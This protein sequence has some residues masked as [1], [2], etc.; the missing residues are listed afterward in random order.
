MILLMTFIKGCCHLER[1]LCALISTDVCP[2]I[3]SPSTL[4]I[5]NYNR[6]LSKRKELLKS[7]L[8]RLQV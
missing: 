5:A 3:K 7:C 1:S 6:N 2:V 4:P 8:G